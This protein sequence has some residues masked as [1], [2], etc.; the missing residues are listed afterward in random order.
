LKG[1][2]ERGM[3]SKRLAKRRRRTKVVQGKV[4]PATVQGQPP[5]ISKGDVRTRLIH[6]ATSG[7]YREDCAAYAGI[8]K[9]TL[10]ESIQR[11][12]EAIAAIERGEDPGPTEKIFADFAA[13]F[14]NALAESKVRTLS[15]IDEASRGI[16]AFRKMGA[17]WTAAAW[18]L[19]R[20]FPDQFGRRVGVENAGGKP[21]A[22][23]EAAAKKPLDVL[24]KEIVEIATALMEESDE[25]ES[26]GDG[27]KRL[28][29]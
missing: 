6:A 22:V 14:K 28:P 23:S 24:K 11:G 13:A 3:T 7:N 8:S 27:K 21:F 12:E 29:S 20:M 18:K 10:Y 17:Q 19:E 2:R 25:E 15:I 26:D 4:V 1:R 9:T 16:G 5:A